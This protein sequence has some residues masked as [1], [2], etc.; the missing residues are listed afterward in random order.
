[1][2]R[3]TRINPGRIGQFAISSSSP[4]VPAS[5]RNPKEGA[6]YAVSVSPLQSQETLDAF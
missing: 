6:Y 3:F 4:D 1:M 2:N 5:T